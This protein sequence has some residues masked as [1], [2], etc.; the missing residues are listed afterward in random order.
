MRMKVLQGMAAGKP[1]VTTSLGA[2]G[3]D[4][5]DPD[6]PL[7]IAE[8]AKELAQESATLL[9]DP[10]RRRELGARARAFAE[11]HHSPAAW[12]RRLEG[13][14]EEARA[15]SGRPAASTARR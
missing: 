12:A 13:V 3:F 14:Y 6:P 1:V 11:H 4:A 7:A 8:T 2:E 5:I 9:A 15:A 10:A